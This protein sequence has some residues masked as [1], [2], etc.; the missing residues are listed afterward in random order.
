M[1]R[2]LVA[3]HLRQRSQIEFPPY[4][5]TP[6]E[7][8]PRGL[9]SETVQWRAGV[10]GSLTWLP[11]AAKSAPVAQ[12]TLDTGAEVELFVDISD[13][14]SKFAPVSSEGFASVVFWCSVPALADLRRRTDAERHIE[15]RGRFIWTHHPDKQGL[16][17]AARAKLRE[18]AAE[19]EEEDRRERE[20]RAK[21]WG[22]VM[23]SPASGRAGS[24]AIDGAG[25][26]GSGKSPSLSSVGAGE[27]AW[28]WAPQRKRNTAFIHYRMRA[29]GAWVIYTLESGSAA[30]A[31]WPIAEEGWDE[32]LPASVGVADS[33]LGVYR[34]S[35]LSSAM[36]FLA[37][38]ASAVRASTDPGDFGGV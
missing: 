35:D 11:P 29:G 10:A 5:Q 33:E 12:G 36:M 16:V 9:L 14:P 32:A 4:T 38:R 2:R 25:A 23:D 34:A 1:L 15:A 37:S 21:H 27:K 6:T 13:D 28:P 22:R 26:G 7:R 8:G 31:P 30:I 3:E 18:R 24:G 20:D 19:L 17:E